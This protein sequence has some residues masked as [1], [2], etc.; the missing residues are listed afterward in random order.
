M[1][2]K[3]LNREDIKEQALKAITEG[4][5]EEQAEVM[6]SWMEIVAEE[7]AQKVTREQSKFN[8]DTMILTNRGIE[9]L[10]SEEVR[11]FEKVA[12]AMKEKNVKQALT[13]LE[14]VMPTTTINRVFEDLEE[15]HPLLKKIRITNVTGVT[16][17]IKRTGDIE[18]AWW[19][20]LCEEIK[21]ELEAGFKKESTTLYKLSAFLPICKAYLVLGPAWLERFIRTILT[22]S[23]KKGLVSA[24][25]SGTGVNQPLGM[26]RDLEAARTPNQ[27]VPQK[28]AVEITDFEPATLGKIIAKLTNN[29]KR[30]VTNVVLIVNPVDYWTKVW[31]LTTTKNALGQYIA[32][33]FPLP[34][35]VIQEPTI[36]Q[37][38][39][40]IG[41][42]DK[43]DLNMGMNKKIEYSDEFRFLEDERVYIT[44]LYANG[45]AVDNNSFEYLDISNV[46]TATLA[47]TEGLSVMTKEELL[48]KAAELNIEGVSENNKKAEIIAAIEAAQ[49]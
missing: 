5:T 14:V 47:A 27:P 36:P 16:E 39:A 18:S 17:T 35:D 25:V 12:E 19:G 42:A 46:S 37:G 7:V 28:N 33:Q 44:K 20:P 48:A 15:S 9:Q 4:N 34:M 40:I 30:A 8:D 49:K 31:V 41:L 2:I 3:N 45:E 6:Q 43:Y 23:I 11:Y 29:G 26:D 21:K 13:E 32:N 24:I 10:T 1:S 38:K 22:E